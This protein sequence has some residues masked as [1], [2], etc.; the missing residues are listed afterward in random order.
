M[1]KEEQLCTLLAK[2]HSYY[3]AILDITQ[4][5][6]GKFLRQRPLNEIAPLTK[7]KQILLACIDEIESE[8]APLKQYWLEGNKDASSTFTQDI[9]QHL[10]QLDTLLKEILRLD[11]ANNEILQQ[12]LFTLKK[13]RACCAA[14][15]PLPSKNL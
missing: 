15:T 5:E 11:K 14:G 13:K 10:K 7:K 6:N 1:S 2:L 9:Q 8:L 3:D 4:E 12:L